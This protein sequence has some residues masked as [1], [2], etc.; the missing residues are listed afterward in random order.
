ML[1]Q[2]FYYWN[3]QQSAESDMIQFHLTH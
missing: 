3:K 1:S 2:T